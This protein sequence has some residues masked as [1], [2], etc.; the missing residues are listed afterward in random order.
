MYFL[1]ALSLSS[2]PLTK[3]ALHFDAQFQMTIRVLKS[4]VCFHSALNSFISKDEEEFI[5]NS[6]NN[7]FKVIHSL[8]SRFRA[9]AEKISSTFYDMLHPKPCFP[10]GHSLSDSPIKECGLVHERLR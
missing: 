2:N 10:D 5:R 8:G 3:P 7:P 6:S 9:D 1:T 4:A